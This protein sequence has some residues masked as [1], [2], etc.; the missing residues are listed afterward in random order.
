MVVV[1]VAALALVITAWSARSPGSAAPGVQPVLASSFEGPS[2]W[3]FQTAV[4]DLATTDRWWH[5]GGDSLL[6]SATAGTPAYV[7]SPLPPLA[8]LWGR[9]WLRVQ[10]RPDA[11]ATV[12]M[13]LTGGSAGMFLK[14]QADGRLAL[15]QQGGAVLGRSAAPL[16]PGRPYLI[17][18]T[19][20]RAFVR[21]V[22]VSGIELA[23]L[24]GS[25][26]TGAATTFKLG[27][28]DRTPTPRAVEIDSVEVWP[29]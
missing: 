28:A 2:P 25:R 23:R 4:G 13:A 8:A 20:P 5:E 17:A 26:E 9:F 27:I 16:V 24:G 1:A 11:G 6:A 15:V 19:W 29:G 10:R 21:L 14:L 18:W 22:S 7:V 3:G 12:V